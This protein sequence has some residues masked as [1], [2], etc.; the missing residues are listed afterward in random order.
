MVRI[1]VLSIIAIMLC[2]ACKED[3]L[4]PTEIARV[5]DE[6]ILF[7][8]L[9]ERRTAITGYFADSVEA[10]KVPVAHWQYRRA[11]QQL[12]VEK[13]VSQHLARKNVVLA[14]GAVQEF[15]DSIRQ[16]YGKQD[17]DQMLMELGITLEQWRAKIEST[18]KTELLIT[19]FLRPNI[20]IS[21]EEVKEYY[22]A[23]KEDFAF[24]EQWRFLQLS[25]LNK[26]VVEEAR[27]ELLASKN[28]FAVK[29]KYSVSIRDIN[30]E[31][32]RLPE[33]IM[34]LLS[35]LES[36]QASA[37]HTGA[38]EYACYVMLEKTP[39][40]VLDLMTI[41][42]RVEQMIAEEKIEP[43]FASWIAGMVEKSDIFVHPYL[44]QEFADEPEAETSGQGAESLET[45]EEEMR[46]LPAEP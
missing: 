19:E 36:W 5:N 40:Q 15:E 44:L 35:K 28:P 13:L 11:L 43:A 17:F 26:D 27:K 37:V 3:K 33:D 32:E 41:Y 4:M 30:I 2:T 38:E 7:S 10:V 20:V 12:I 29:A 42:D 1:F 18:L 9:E 34:K 14:E 21:P 23:N 6:W 24:S 16:E 46:N 39:P 8:E 45:T 25:S 22:E 31:K